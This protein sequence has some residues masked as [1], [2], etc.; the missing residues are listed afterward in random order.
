METPQMKSQMGPKILQSNKSWIN[1][2]ILQHLLGQNCGRRVS[3]QQIG[4]WNLVH[5][6]LM[7]AFLQGES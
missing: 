4:N 6:D 5:V 7:T 2:L 1:K 3:E